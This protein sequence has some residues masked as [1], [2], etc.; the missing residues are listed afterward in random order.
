MKFEWSGTDDPFKY[1]EELK[2]GDSNSYLIE[3]NKMEEIKLDKMI[4]IDEKKFT[5]PLIKILDFFNE[6]LLKLTEW[7]GDKITDLEMKLYN[8]KK[9]KKNVGRY[10]KKS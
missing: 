8:K 9:G 5:S 4:E 2:T 7:T 10:N 1:I 3:Y 6:F